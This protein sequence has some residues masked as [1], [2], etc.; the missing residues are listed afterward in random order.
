MQS[1]PLLL[2]SRQRLPLPRA[3]S[4]WPRCHAA[5][6]LTHAVLCFV[7]LRSTHAGPA[8]SAAWNET[9]D[10][11]ATIVMQPNKLW[12]TVHTLIHNCLDPMPPRQVCGRASLPGLAPS[13]FWLVAALQCC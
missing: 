8:Y 1:L 9:A 6:T 2:G 4:L 13:W 11:T 10:K 7:M 5:A 3:G 12:S